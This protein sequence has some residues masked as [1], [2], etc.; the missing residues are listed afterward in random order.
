MKA[1]RWQ[2]IEEL[3]G[4]ALEIAPDE[5]AVFLM[6]ECGSDDA[7]RREVET[8]LASHKRAGDFIQAPAFEEAI[9]LIKAPEQTL[10]KGHRIG[11]YEIICEIGRGG[12]GAVYLATRADD[13]YKKRVAIKLIKRG[14]DTDDIL[15]RFRNE[16]QILASLD[17][18]NIARLLDGGTTDE[19][20]PYFVMEY[21]EGLPLMDYCDRERLSTV[22]RLKLFRKICAAVQHAHQN[23]V[24]HRDLKPS[25]IIVTAGGEPKLLDFGIAKF[26]NPEMSAHTIA[27]TAT[28]MRLM[29]R[30]YASP[31]QVRGQP[32][33]TASDVYSLGVLLYR[34]LTGHHPYQFKTPLPSEVER[35]ICETEPQRPSDAVKRVEEVTTSD[36]E[37]VQLTPELVSSTRDGEPQKLRRM[38]SGDLDT[39]I[40]MAMRKEPARRYS[41][42]EQFS[43]DIRRY[44]EGLPV[45]A[46]KDTF[47]YRASKFV[48]RHRAGV[49]A[50]T[51][52]AIAIIAGIVA[53]LWQARIAREQ[54][55]AARLAQ[56]KAERISKFLSAALSYSDP[57]AAFAGTKNRRGATIN[58]MLDDIAPRIETEL[59][60]QPEVRASIERTVGY[61]Y[62]AQHRDAE[63][64][65][66]LNIALE[67]QLKIYGEDSQETAYTLAGLALV[68]ANKGNY[69][70]AE[71][72]LQKVIATY[73]NNPP[74]EQIHIKVF[75][76]ALVD[77]GDVQ[78]TKGDYNAA[79][80]A[81][82]EALTFASHL[83][84]RDRQLI[85][86][87][88]A[89]L[90][91]GRYAQGR[92]DEAVSLL[93]EAADEY[94]S[95][96]HTQWKLPF[97]LN[98]LAQVLT[99]KGEYDHALTVLRESEAVSLEIWG[100]NNF[101]YPRSLWLEVY[102]FCFKGD[103]DKA[104]KSLNRAEE[105]YN[106]NFPD[107]KV[108]MAN[109][110]DARCL[111]LTR[112]GRARQG[113]MSGRQAVELY[114]GSIN[115]GAASTTL[116]RIHLAENLTAQKKYDEAERIL[117]EAY[118]DASDVQGAQHWRTKDVARELI[119]LYELRNRPDLAA[120][121][122][123]LPV[124]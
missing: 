52:V 108:V 47:A 75:V 20:L 35:V 82:N 48:R 12:M 124:N 32:I 111:I 94:R 76:G 26:L 117:L 73:R 50:A 53:T 105:I 74:T 31:E 103:Y 119:K 15:R 45:L 22:E 60:D 10:P 38:L 28:A 66:Y 86:D 11:P 122:R 98:F 88:K 61:A 84:G 90:G 29:T 57:A 24:V 19:G 93:G 69:A 116:A 112:T 6:N 81:Y 43:E 104:E 123:A 91:R 44:L 4:A 7:L 120:Q 113:E 21:V 25:N 56:T 102:A 77:F 41:S 42:V 71:R 115:R 30:D 13:E 9:G 3:F 67:T 107:N 16:R 121:Y 54:R 51:L 85:T 68:Q 92:L 34:L 64:E 65:R 100:E 101:D 46:R 1:E 5:R 78:W 114:E 33:T 87:A 2:R 55:D 62:I 118:K 99:W 79:E 109:L 89:G 80:S 106:R 40:L 70:E 83:Q 49:A 72:M 8:L 97:A 23:L 96:P 58:Q 63:A 95:Q 59:A 110:Y 37:S 17:H 39:I 36:G 18:P 14:L 27:P